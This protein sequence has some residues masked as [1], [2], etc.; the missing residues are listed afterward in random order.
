[1]RVEK[2]EA[3]LFYEKECADNNWSARELE[4]QKGALLFERLTLSKDKKGLMR[5]ARRGMSC[6]PMKT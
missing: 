5:L 2:P 3:R 4:R 6:K 1:M